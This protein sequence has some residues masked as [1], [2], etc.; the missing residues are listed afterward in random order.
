MWPKIGLYDHKWH[1]EK[2]RAGLGG[3][4]AL[5]E[6]AFKIGAAKELLAWIGGW[7]GQI[8]PDQDENWEK[9]GTIPDFVKEKRELPGKFEPF[10]SFAITS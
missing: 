7:I 1:N 6:R 4:E 2:I 9:C 3:L 8:H 10:F 5:L